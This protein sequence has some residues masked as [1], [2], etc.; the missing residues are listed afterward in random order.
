[1]TVNHD[2]FLD[3]NFVTTAKKTFRFM[4]SSA[5]GRSDWW[6]FPDSRRLRVG[7]TPG[8]LAHQLQVAYRVLVA[9]VIGRCFSL[10]REKYVSRL[11]RGPF[12]LKVPFDR[13]RG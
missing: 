10:G 7:I 11:W 12:P 13:S 6:G 3:G 9:V 8:A 2:R 5:A 4:G 1:M